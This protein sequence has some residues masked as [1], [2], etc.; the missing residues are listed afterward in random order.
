LLFPGRADGNPDD[1]DP[2]FGHAR[3]DGTSWTSTY[4]VR[5]GQKLYDSEQDYT[6]LGAIH[7]NSPYTIYA[8]TATDPRDDSTTTQRREIWR[9]TTCDEGATFAWTPI[10]QNSTLD[11]VR[12]I[13]P[14]WDSR[15]TGLL[16]TRGTFT[17]VS[18]QNSDIAG[19]ILDGR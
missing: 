7:P 15:R 10:T 18:V 19:L 11:N 12:P 17:F 2:R 8:S 14:Y 13:V 9:G 5:G 16:W 6:G 3:F 4:L 1:P